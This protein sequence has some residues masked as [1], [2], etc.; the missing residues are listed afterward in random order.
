MKGIATWRQT[1]EAGELSLKPAGLS[2]L[3]RH[4]TVVEIAIALPSGDSSL[5]AIELEKS[6]RH[7]I[8]RVFFLQTVGIGAL[9]VGK[10]RHHFQVDQLVHH[11]E[12]H[13]LQHRGE[14]QIVVGG[15]EHL[16][17]GGLLVAVPVDI[18]DGFRLQVAGAHYY[19]GDFPLL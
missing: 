11:G 4:S 5:A 6:V 16:N 18:A 7:V 1:A 3:Q 8:D 15:V 2:R 13:V 19:H 10:Y 12:F 14:G 9:Q 17:D